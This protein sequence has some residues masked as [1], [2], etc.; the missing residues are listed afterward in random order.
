MSDEIDTQ[1]CVC[2]SDN[3]HGSIPIGPGAADWLKESRGLEW[4]PHPYVAPACVSCEPHPTIWHH[5]SA[6]LWE[7]VNSDKEISERTAYLN[8]EA[9]DVLNS[10][11]LDE[12]VMRDDFGNWVPL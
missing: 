7:P 9:E 10:L 3:P 11:D 1:C 8:N 4:A 6:G 12:L 5:I 2:G